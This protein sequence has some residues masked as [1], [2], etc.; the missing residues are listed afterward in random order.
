MD[1]VPI[2]EAAQRLGITVEAVRKRARRGSL[3][4]YKTDGLWH[5]VLPDGL[6]DMPE[7]RQD[8]GRATGRDG[9]D[10]PQSASDAPDMAITRDL[11]DTLRAELNVK[12]RQIERLTALLGNAQQTVQMLSAGH[13]DASESPPP[14]VDE[15][16][17]FRPAQ[18]SLHVAERPQRASWRWPWERRG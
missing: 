6:P 2:Q 9:S 13:S 16:M 15:E 7:P 17:A 12:N 10:A 4:A 8:A 1:G 11:V 5:I 3:T 14:T 18:T